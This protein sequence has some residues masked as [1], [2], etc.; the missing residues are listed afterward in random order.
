M[1]LIRAEFGVFSFALKVVRLWKGKGLYGFV[2]KVREASY[3][4]QAG[5]LF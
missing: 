2:L 4:S 1:A 5:C 3:L